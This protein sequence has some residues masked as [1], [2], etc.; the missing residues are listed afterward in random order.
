M[1]IRVLIFEDEIA[2]IR[3]YKM[4]LKDRGYEIR[5]FED[6]TFCPLYKEKECICQ[7]DCMCADIIITDIQMPKIDGLTFIKEQK[8]KGCKVKNIIVISAFINEGVQDDAK[9]LGCSFMQKPFDMKDLFKWLDACEKTID[10]KR[11]LAK[12]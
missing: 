9:K 4:M 1:K 2:I 6:P 12:W 11:K 7:F 3:L 8:E 10:P 5:T